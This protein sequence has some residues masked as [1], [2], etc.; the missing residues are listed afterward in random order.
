MIIDLWFSIDK[1]IYRC[2]NIYI[3]YLQGEV[4]FLTGG[5]RSLTLAHEPKNTSRRFGVIPKPT[6]QSGRKKKKY[7]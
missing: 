1:F 5:N 6:V 7:F 4:Q 3:K 2:Y